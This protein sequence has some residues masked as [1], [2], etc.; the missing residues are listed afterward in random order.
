M[1]FF[2]V[3]CDAFWPEKCIGYIFV[4]CIDACFL[5][6][7]I[8]SHK[9]SQQ[10][11]W[12]HASRIQVIKL[13]PP[14]WIYRIHP[15]PLS[16]SLSDE[17]QQVGSSDE[18]VMNNRGW[19]KLGVASQLLLYAILYAMNT[20]PAAFII[21]AAS[22]CQTGFKLETPKLLTIKSL[23]NLIPTVES[24]SFYLGGWWP[25]TIY[26]YITAYDIQ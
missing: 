15:S 1:G 8:S 16:N 17:Q 10:W 12:R 6:F 7:N 21:P 22:L 2:C 26:I 9:P 25:T 19:G 3:Q 20:I 13:K 18:L 5:W 11:V 14:C 4:H 24:I 23:K